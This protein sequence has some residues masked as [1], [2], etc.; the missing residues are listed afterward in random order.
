MD[1]CRESRGTKSEQF[2]LAVHFDFP[3]VAKDLVT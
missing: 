2:S 1:G 3:K